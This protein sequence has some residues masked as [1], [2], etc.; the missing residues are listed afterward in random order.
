MTKMF[1]SLPLAL[2]LG[3]P[4]VAS[5][6]T[7]YGA[8]V[9]V[10]SGL[11]IDVPGFYTGNIQVQQYSCNYGRNQMWTE[12]STGTPG[13]YTIRALHSGKCLEIAGW[14]TGNGQLAQHYTC[15]G[16]AN[17]RWYKVD[18]GGG[19]YA[20]INAYSGKCLDVDGSSQSGYPLQQWT[21]HFGDNQRFE[22][23]LYGVAV[24]P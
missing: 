4:G 6:T 7:Y 2:L 18:L 21:C 13:W 14:S 17:Q 19:E 1:A 9:S 5:A 16:G 22:G 12:V 23:G 8:M 24:T 15:N 11:C 20:Y 3:L 10:D